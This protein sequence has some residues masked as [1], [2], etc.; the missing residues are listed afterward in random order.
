MSFGRSKPFG[1][2]ALLG[3]LGLLGFVSIASADTFDAPVKRKV[4]DMGLSSGNLPGQHFR[5]QLYCWFYPNF[6]VKEED[7]PQ[8]K[9]ARWLAIIP[10]E[11]GAEPACTRVQ[12]SSEMRIKWSGYFEGV[13]GNLVFF[14]A[15]D[16]TDGGLP[17]V[18]YDSRTGKKIFEDSAYD[19]TIWNYKAG[20]SPFNHIRV[21][22][23]PDRDFTMTYLRVVEADCDLH[24]EKAACWERVR[25]KL[26]LKSDQM[27]VCTDYEGISSFWTSAVAYPVEVSLFPRPTR[28]TVA[29]PVKCWPVD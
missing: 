27:P 7:D 24:T 1:H 22:G 8:E 17:F 18:I 5:V 2:I 29:G 3:A 10:F 20:D 11:Q 16:G 14:G 26:A 19:S 25:K 28:K 4:V 6:M 12:I 15:A 21:S 23:G 13:K 9:G